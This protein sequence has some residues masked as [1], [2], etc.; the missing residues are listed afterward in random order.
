MPGI[1]GRLTLEEENGSPC[2]HSNLKGEKYTR[3]RKSSTV[4]EMVTENLDV[5]MRKNE[6]TALFLKSM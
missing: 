2:N 3:W 6:T 4:N 5:Y 1:A